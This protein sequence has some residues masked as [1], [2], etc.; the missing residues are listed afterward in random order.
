MIASTG[1]TTRRD[2]ILIIGLACAAFAPSLLTR[3]VWNPDEPRYIEVAREMVATG[4]YI[5]PHLNGELYPDKPAPIF[6][7]FAA[8]YELG[9][10][11]QGGRV[12]ALLSAIGT[13]WFTYLLGRR[14]YGPQ[15]GLLGA[16]I[17]LTSG[18]FLQI[19][20]YGVLDPPLA[21][22]VVA[23]V[24]CGYRAL[25]AGEARGRWWLVFYA[26]VACGISIKGPVAL[27]T[28]GLILLV[29]AL[30]HR[31]E[32]RGGGWWHLGG[33][34][35]L[36]AI[37]AAWL[38]P[39]CIQG[40]EAYRNDILVNQTVRRV[41]QS[42][43]HRQPPWFYLLQS[44][45]YF[46]PWVFVGILALAWAVRQARQKG[47]AGWSLDLVWFVVMFMFFS[48]VSGKRERYLLPIVP[49]AG[50]LTA[51]YVCGIARGAL[52]ASRWHAWLWRVTFVLVAVLGGAL[53]ASGVLP[54]QWANAAKLD[55]ADQAILWQGVTPW[56]RVAAITGG[57][58]LL[59]VSFHGARQAR[60]AAGE[61]RRAGTLVCSVMVLALAVQLALM[62]VMNGFKSAR[63]FVAEAQPC[64]D[65]ADEVYVYRSDLSGVYNLF[66]GINHMPQLEDSGEVQK[67]FE[68][69]KRVAVVVRKS[70]KMTAKETVAELR[71]HLA[72]ERRVGSRIM[73]LITN[74]KPEA[75]K[76]P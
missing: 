12:V 15:V 1:T 38:V 42:D 41:A 66:S 9:F 57:V 48:A 30:L 50:L 19:V 59:L 6:W 26:A 60:G 67:A 17:T 10:G 29:Y 63:Y 31:R 2:A 70:R 76:S 7:T 64:L 24:Y 43:S 55:A 33:A 25:H 22:F 62:P 3:D 32:V 39:A 37:V 73:L 72:A 65:Q 28:P 16:L 71:G 54:G 20:S 61:L 49:A 8:F 58:A 4:E 35:L 75:P 44:P 23:S 18:L 47:R 11:I 5:V 13:L 74:W 68:S 69:A 14:L 56:V 40:G 21:F 36:L 53:V 52:E 34:A 46:F 51:R 27:A 45:G